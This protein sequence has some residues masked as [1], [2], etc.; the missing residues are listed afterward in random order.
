MNLKTRVLAAGAVAGAL[1]GILGAYLYLRSVPVEF[2]G[3]GDDRLPTVNPGRAI[4]IG[5]STLTLLRQ[6]VGLGQH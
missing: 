5:L 3:E 4:A 1:L 2:D 6:I